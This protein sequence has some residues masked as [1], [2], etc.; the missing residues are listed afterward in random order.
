MSSLK[1]LRQKVKEKIHHAHIG[2]QGCLRRAREVVY[3]PSMNQE[4]SDY[5]EHCDTCNMYTSHPQREPLI[6]HDVP[7][8]PWQ[9]VGCDIFTLDEK[10]YLCT[11][12]YYSGYFEI[13]HLERKTARAIITRSK[14]HYF[15]H[16]IPNVFQ[17]DNGPPFDSQEFRD[18][19][20]LDWR[21]TPTEVVGCSPMQRLCGRRTRT[22]LPTATSLLKPSLTLGVRDKRLK[23][24][25]RQTYYY[26]RG[27][28]ELS[29][30]RKGDA[31]VMLPSPQARK[32]KK[33]QVEDQVDV[34]SYAV[35][36]EDG[37]VFRRNRRHLKKY[38]PPPAIHTPEMEVGPSKITATSTPP[39]EG[40][41]KE[42]EEPPIE[43]PQ[44]V[45][46]DLSTLPSSPTVPAPAPVEDPAAGDGAATRS[47]HQIKLPTRFK[48]FKMT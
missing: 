24:K 31:V 2:I 32:W 15:N 43:P 21:N 19:A 42:S 11:V 14:R 47:G 12:D 1:T 40:A 26:N 34:R 10:D 16:G 3:W 37:R 48:D 8:R 28:R 23:K 33:A 22:L 45:S 30:L 13:D 18:L 17:S 38:D 41:V 44:L 5:I 25:E 46:A 4:I 7:E 35:R 9:K 6:V 36:T 29:P 20:L 39:A 27:T